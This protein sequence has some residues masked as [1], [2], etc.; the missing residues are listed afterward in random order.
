MQETITLLFA[1]VRFGS[2]PV[3]LLASVGENA[4]RRMSKQEDMWEGVMANSAGLDRGVLDPKRTTAK[5]V[6]AFFIQYS[7]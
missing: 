5:S 7:L 1:I 2:N 4:A 6:W 3:L